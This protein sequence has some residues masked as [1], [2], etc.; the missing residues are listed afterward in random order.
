MLDYLKQLQGKCSTHCSVYT[1]PLN[2]SFDECLQ[3][4][5]GSEDNRRRTGATGPVTQ[6]SAK[7]QG[8]DVQ[9]SLYQTARGTSE[10]MLRLLKKFR[11]AL[12][13]CLNDLNYATRELVLEY[14]GEST[15]Y[16]ERKLREAWPRL[17]QDESLIQTRVNRTNRLEYGLP[18]DLDSNSKVAVPKKGVRDGRATEVSFTE[19]NGN[20]TGG[21]CEDCKSCR[22]DAV[23]CS[24]SIGVSRKE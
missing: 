5:L 16:A 14:S 10:P 24:N 15:N 2:R 19:Q 23:A 11:P 18:R 7:L 4:C 13:Q 1:M 17:L 3:T 6:D 8:L 12:K 22:E 20:D 9:A 21:I